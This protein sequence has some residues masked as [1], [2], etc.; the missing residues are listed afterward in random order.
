MEQRYIDEFFATGRLMLSSFVRFAAHEDEE[1]QDGEE[2]RNIVTIAGENLTVIAGLGHGDHSYI[3]CTSC[4]GD[5]DMMVQFGCD[6]YFQIN[7]TTGFGRAIA[8]KLNATEGLEG[9]CIYRDRNV[10]RRNVGKLTLDQFRRGANPNFHSDPVIGAIFGYAGADV[11]FS[12]HTRYSH[13]AEYRF[14]WNVREP[15]RN[16]MIMV[17]CPDAVQYCEKVTGRG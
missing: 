4:R 17:E 16:S 15:I 9:L 2:G 8:Q 3:L 13:Q 7:D 14:I 5:Q 12:K 1:R 6:G 10:L 11:F